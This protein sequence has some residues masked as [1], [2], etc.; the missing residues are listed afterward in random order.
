MTKI[1]YGAQC[2]FW[3]SIEDAGL[4]SM[5]GHGVPCC[6]FC[7]GMLFEVSDPAKWQASIDRHAAVEP[8]YP[9]IMAWS[10]GACLGDSMDHLRQ[11]YQMREFWRPIRISLSPSKTIVGVMRPEDSARL[12]EM[13]A[14]FETYDDAVAWCERW[15]SGEEP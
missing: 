14:F 13:G 3:G 7:G 5:D 8:D 12:M 4:T 9:A 1:V 6:P 11:A 15:N 10:R 2:T